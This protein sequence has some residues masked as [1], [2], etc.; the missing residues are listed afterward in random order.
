VPDP[1]SRKETS[2]ERQAGRSPFFGRDRG[3]FKAKLTHR[4]PRLSDRRALRP[5][6]VC[7]AHDYV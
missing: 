5:L 2:T 6:D 7:A 3:R 4:N 1:G